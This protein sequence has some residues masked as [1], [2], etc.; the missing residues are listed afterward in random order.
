VIKAVFDTNL[1]AS[2]FLRADTPP[3]QLIDAW[4]AGQCELIVSEY[5]LT[6]LARTLR[7]PYF[8][9][10]LTPEQ[11]AR[12]LTLLRRR[13]T[14]T[15]IM[16]EVTGVATHPEDDPVLATTVSAEADYLVTGDGRLRR[17]VPVLQGVTLISPRDFLVFLV[18]AI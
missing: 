5:L 1:L 14:I 10:R 15:P 3:G 13:A 7:K 2:G 12:A 17:Q 11:I 4:R 8:A 18:E 16:V 6:E 9:Q